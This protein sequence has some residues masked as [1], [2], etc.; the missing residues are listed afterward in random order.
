MNEL[1]IL[2]LVDIM[3][4]G[5]TI[6]KLH[7]LKGM[8]ERLERMNKIFLFGNDNGDIILLLNSKEHEV[9]YPRQ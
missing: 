7:Q 1:C 9:Y 2:G 5:T 8:L 3:M 4:K 6:K